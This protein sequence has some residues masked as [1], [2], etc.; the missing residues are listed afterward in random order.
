MFDIA[1]FPDYYSILNL[2]YGSSNEVIKKYY[3]TLAKVFHPDNKRTGKEDKFILIKKAYD[4]LNST[5]REIYDKLYLKYSLLKRKISDTKQTIQLRPDRINYTTS[6]Q[7]L[8]KRGLLK[9]GFR[10]KDRSKFTGLNHDIDLYVKKEEL[11]KRISIKLPLVVRILCPECRGS[12][13]HCECCNGI[14]TYKSTRNL[15]IIFEPEIIANNRIYEF[16]LSH[17][18]PDKFIHFKKKKIKIK[19]EVKD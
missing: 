19:I 14:G 13:V 9:T 8:A 12:N 16:E 10:K 2:P 15:G 7:F 6:I 4:V 5:D 1:S 3:Y 11:G 18:R 17:F